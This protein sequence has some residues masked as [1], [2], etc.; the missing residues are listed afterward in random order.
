MQD[1]PPPPDDDSRPPPHGYPYGAPGGHAYGYD[2]RYG[3]GPPGVPPGGYRQ[4]APTNPQDTNWAVGIYMGTLFAGILV[5]L[6]IYFAK[7]S[8]SAFVRFHAAQALNYQLTVMIQMFAP[9]LVLVPIAI[10]ADTPVFLIP[11]IPIFFFHAIAQYVFLILATVR[12]AKGELY[13]LPTVVC[14]RMVR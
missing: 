13:R 4:G 8:D 10:L 14:F 1:A 5:P 11:I 6:V 3:Y 9:L 12:S 2:P 7:R